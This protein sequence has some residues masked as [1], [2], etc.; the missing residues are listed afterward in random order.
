M[1]FSSWSVNGYAVG[2]VRSESGSVHGPWQLQ[3]EPLY[4]ENGGHGMFFRDLEGRLLLT[5]HHPNDPL[6][7]RPHFWKIQSESETLILGGQE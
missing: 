3:V 4:P 5:L 2:E 7:E 6:Q 1:I